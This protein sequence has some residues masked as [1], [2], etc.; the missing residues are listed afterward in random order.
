MSN[1]SDSRLGKSLKT[2]VIGFGKMAASLSDCAKVARFYP[3]FT[4]AQVL[5]DHPNFDW[6]SVVDIDGAARDEAKS[7]WGIADVADCVEGLTNAADIEVA[8]LATP[9][10]HRLSLVEKL[11]NLKAVLTEKPLGRDNVDAGTFLDHCQERGILLQ[12]NYPRRGDDR[13]LD[14]AAGGLEKYVGDIQVVFGIYGNGL[15]NNGSHMVDTCRLLFGEVIGVQALR[16]HEDHLDLPIQ[17][18][19]AVDFILFMDGGIDVTLRAV[20]FRHYRENG[21]D[22]WGSAGRLTIYQ[23]M[24]DF[25]HFNLG[26]C[27]IL[28]HHYEIVSDLGGLRVYE[29]QSMAYRNIYD[30]LFRAVNV[31]EL[32]I[33][34]GENAR[35]N[36]RIIETITVSAAGNGQRI[37]L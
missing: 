37:S 8:V 30:N 13:F 23:E 10:E 32:L 28:D 36:E 19:E 27:R 31:G 9:P 16:R 6:V 26:E 21:L 2:A 20:D 5:K 7:R 24:T 29:E 17:G 22:I 18:D 25:R 14:L 3:L 12:V 11:P 35:I 33:S 34:S 1:P 4:H 15:R